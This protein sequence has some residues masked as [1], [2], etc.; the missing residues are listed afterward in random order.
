VRLRGL[1][2]LSYS[3]NG[4]RYQML[5]SRGV[6]AWLQLLGAP[7]NRRCVPQTNFIILMGVGIRS[8]RISSFPA[9]PHSW[10]CA[11]AVFFEE[12]IRTGICLCK[13]INVLFFPESARPKAG[14]GD[15]GRKGIWLTIPTCIH[16][17]ALLRQ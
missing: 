15:S 17:T 14:P 5:R 9:E 7:S 12:L 3:M 10:F 1:G 8:L 2:D 13:I 16:G 4:R 11:L 6:P